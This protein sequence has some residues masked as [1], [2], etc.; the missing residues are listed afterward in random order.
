[1]KDKF[2]FE[3]TDGW[4][5]LYDNRQWMI[6]RARKRHAQEVW[7]PVSFIES[8]KTAL[9]VCMRQK[10]IVP[11]PEA[12]AKLDKMPERFRDWLQE[13]LGGNVNG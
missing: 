6:C 7:H 11:T 1:M 2:L 9:L 12:Q 5:L 4:A 3:L 13:H 10:G 8:T